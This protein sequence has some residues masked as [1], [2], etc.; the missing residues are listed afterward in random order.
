MIH[1]A[2]Y[3]NLRDFGAACNS[4]STRVILSDA[5]LFAVRIT[6]IMTVSKDSSA[7]QPS[8]T[9]NSA[10]APVFHDDGKQG[11]NSSWYM[12]SFH[13]VCAGVSS[14]NVFISLFCD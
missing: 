5:A 14:S 2:F 10:D 6:S 11:G 13:M 8:R 4:A 7:S 1:G 3:S 12:G 9:A